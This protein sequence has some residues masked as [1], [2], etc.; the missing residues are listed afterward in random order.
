MNHSMV[1]YLL[2]KL[3]LIEAALLVVPLIVATIYQ[4][5]ATV[6]KAIIATQGILILLGVIG[7]CFKPKNYRIYTKEGL[8]IT[9]MT[10]ILWSFFGGLPFVFAGQIPDVID[11]FFEISSGFT[12]TG[13]TILPN[14]AVLSPSLMFWRSFTHLIGGMGVLVF[15]LAIMENSKNAHLEVMR[16]EVPGPVFGKVVAKLKN[17]AQ[18]LYII[19]LVMFL[20]F[21][22]VLWGL[23]MPLYDSLVI[24]MGGAGTGG[25]AVYNDSIAH[26]NSSAISYAVSIGTLLFGVN[27]NLYYF[28]LVR[29]VKA[30]FSD[31]ELRVYLGIVLASSAMI[32]INIYHLYANLSQ[33]VEYSFFQVATIIT[34]TGFGITDLTKWP[35]FSQVI[36]LMLMFIGGS[37]GST[38]GGFKVI[39]AMVVAKIS[40]SQILSSISPNRILTIH[41]ND[42]PLD[43]ATQHSILKYLSVYLMILVGLIIFLSADGKDFMITVSA[44]ASTFNNIGPILG[45]SETFAIFSPLSKFVLSL[46][47]IAGRLE[48]YPMLLLFLPRSWNKY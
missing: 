20:I 25:F 4:E 10:W 21:T 33:T 26:Y 23:G 28:I 36:L 46:A 34:T 3:L 15:A 2:S 6:F 44:V 17:T 24:A 35:L 5:E 30:F 7:I 43:K 9:A 12:T 32:A 37:A 18:I 40:R 39:R 27:F 8:L 14:V 1:R 16:A 42:S 48:I 29:K 31:E 19:Y 41:V 13:A 11:A 22:L 47:M 45:T 38:A